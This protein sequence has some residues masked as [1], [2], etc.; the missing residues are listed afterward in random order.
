[1]KKKI[2]G[3]LAVMTILLG[4]I[5][6]AYAA[7]TNNIGFRFKINSYQSNSFSTA[8]KRSTKNPKCAWMVD[9]RKSTESTSGAR[10]V[11]RFWLEKSQLI[12]KQVSDDVDVLEGSGPIFTASTKEGTQCDVKLGA[13][14]NNYSAITYEATGYWDEETAV[15]K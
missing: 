9:F 4:G 6:Q 3:T 12:G 10:C 13:E 7:E 11:T 15:T 5:S 14:N 8:R 1:M 2:F